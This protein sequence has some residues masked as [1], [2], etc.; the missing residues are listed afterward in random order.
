M[1]FFEK[2]DKKYIE[3]PELMRDLR[4]ALILLLLPMIYAVVITI[5]E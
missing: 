1:R 2:K 3:H 4:I 5:F